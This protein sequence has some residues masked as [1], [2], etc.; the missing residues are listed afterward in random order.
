MTGGPRHVLLL[1]GPF[2]WFFT[3]LGRAL[4]ARGARVTRVLLCPGDAL[5]WRGPGAVSFRGRPEGWPGWVARLA[6]RE[7]VTDLVCL[8]DGRFWHRAAIEAL[9]AVTAHVVEQGYLRPGWLTHETGG[10]GGRSRFPRDAEAVRAL[11]GPEPA[12]PRFRSSFA[13]FSAMD[14]GYNLANLLAGRILWPH[15]RT[16]MLDGPLKEWTGWAGKAARWPWRRA[17]QDAALARIAAHEGPVFLMALQLETD[18]Q[19]RD[20]GP[21]GGLR[22]ALA[23]V[24][25]SFR[26]HA[27]AGALLVVKPHPLDNGWTPWRRL[28]E[29]AIYLDGG[30]LEA[31]F[32]KLS[33]L[34]TVNSTAGLSA[35]RAGVP[36]SVLGRAIYD[37][38]GLTHRGGLDAFWTAPMPPDP[39]LA[40]ALVRALAATIQVPGGFDG[41]GAVPGAEAIAARIMEGGAWPGPEASS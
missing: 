35:V 33:G 4:R 23:R 29:G 21:E 30:S 41:E 36:V 17:A 14:V 27:P 28:S 10:T 12:M 39:G 11:A 6:A 2:S 40:A 22:A 37:I 16:H 9:P 7:A 34:V 26:A 24:I 18:F 1:Q 32:P 8:G 19:I 38:E 25:A 15:F 5:F 13:S 20:H 3:I 31:L